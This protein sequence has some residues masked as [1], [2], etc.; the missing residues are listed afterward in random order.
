MRRSS[1]RAHLA[2]L[3]CLILLLNL[4]RI[5]IASQLSRHIHYTAAR[6]SLAVVVMTV[7]AIAVTFG[8]APHNNRAVVLPP[9]YAIEALKKAGTVG[10]SHNQITLLRDGDGD[11]RFEI[12]E[13][14]LSG[15]SQPFG[16]LLVNDYFYVANTDSVV[17]YHYVKDARR[18]TD[19]GEK[20]VDLPAGGYNN[21]WTRNIVASPKGDK[22]YVSVGSQTN[23]DKEGLDAKEPRRAAILEC[24]PDGSGV[25]V[26][27]SGLRNPNG[28]DWAPGT[29]TM[30]AVACGACSPRW[31]NDSGT[32]DGPL[33]PR[34]C[35]RRRL[36]RGRLV[37]AVR[38]PPSSLRSQSPD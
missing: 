6:V 21:H 4:I 8:Q 31:V 24:N 25:R 20:I 37:A 17:R 26:F 11:G 3:E 7:V 22:L 5:Q 36:T 30:G 38:V 27:A 9:P 14:L 10:P 29:T 19:K 15:L 2:R 28:M 1:T 32:T 23:V 13:V 12:R 35:V 16:M 18:L 33:R 34:R